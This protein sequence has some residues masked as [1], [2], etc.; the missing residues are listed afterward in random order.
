MENASKALIMAAG[1]L[2]GVMII[3]LGVYLFYTFSS[4][5]SQVHRE[6]EQ[7]QLDQFNSQFLKYNG[8]NVNIYDVVTIASLAKENN[9]E[10][11][12][13]SKTNNNFYIQVIFPGKGNIEKNNNDKNIEL[14]KENNKTTGTNK[15][16]Q[17]FKCTVSINGNT[18]RVDSI[19]FNK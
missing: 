17:T 11:G 2:I 12:L 9:E 16:L 6:N 18:A 1:V 10:Y 4:S 8:L 13:T 3:S 19:R 14:I 15:E 7:A 5:A